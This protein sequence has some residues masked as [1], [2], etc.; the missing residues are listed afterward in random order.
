[1]PTG[2]WCSQWWWVCY[3]TVTRHSQYKKVRVLNQQDS[4]DAAV[5]LRVIRH[6]SVFTWKVTA[7]NKW[8]HTVFTESWLFFL[9]THLNIDISLSSPVLVFFL[10]PDDFSSLCDQT[11]LADIYLHHCSFGDD[12]Q[13][14]VEGRGGVLLHAEDGEAEGGL[15]LWV[16]DVSLFE[17]QALRWGQWTKTRWLKIGHLCENIGKNYA[18]IL[19]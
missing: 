17:T 3:F 13:G 18:V 8:Q 15:Q 4:V 6:L 16:C 2:R 5:V 12:A 1:M 10:T 14:G 11:Q 9:T 7:V 19:P